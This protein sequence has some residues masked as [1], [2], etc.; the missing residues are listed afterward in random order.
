[1]GTST[2]NDGAGPFDDGSPEVPGGAARPVDRVIVVGAGIAGLTVANALT[3]A[4]V[5]VVVLEARERIGG[6]LHTV[7][8]GGSPV[9]LGGAWIHTPDGNPMSTLADLLGVARAPVDFLDSATLIDAD[10]NLDALAPLLPALDSFYGWLDRERATLDASRS[11][12]DEIDRFLSG[13][14]EA[15]DRG[16]LRRFFR[17][18]M[19][20]EDAWPP[21]DALAREFPPNTVEFEGS[22]LG[23]FPDGGYGRILDGLAAGLD[24][25]TS[26]PVR[27][28]ARDEDGVTVRIHGRDEPLTGSHIV[29]TVPLGVLKDP[30]AVAFAPALPA[31]RRAAIDRLGFGRFE[32]VILRFHEPFWRRDEPFA[33]IPDVDAGDWL[34]CFELHAFTGAPVL[35]AF[36]I[37]PA[38]DRALGRPLADRVDEVLALVR[39]S[40]GIDPPTPT[41]VVASGWTDDPY[42]R[43][44]YSFLR[45]GS[46]REDLDLLGEPIDGRLLFA[47]EGT[48]SA[49]A[50]FADGAMRTGIREAKRLMGTPQVRLGRL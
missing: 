1:M 38:A 50:G 3:H 34:V 30:D 41:D 26:Q 4:G 29:V 40:T 46:S 39:A 24:V 36:S 49:R 44:A 27:E 42:A 45:I 20:A 17:A 9:D 11:L 2:T 32:K 21:D 28:I 13:Y 7:D 47:G 15:G 33:V 14:E 19:T 35:V 31:E 48:G 6:R 43:G 23:E 10:G 16:A 5:E 37:G 22:A 8:L 25:R 18:L 12:A